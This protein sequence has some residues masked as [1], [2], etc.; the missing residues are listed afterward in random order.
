M[1]PTAGYWV[2]DALFQ[3]DLHSSTQKE[4]EI[5]GGKGAVSPDRIL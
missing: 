3:L 4:R 1:A 2:M 5:A